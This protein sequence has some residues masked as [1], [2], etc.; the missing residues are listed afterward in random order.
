MLFAKIKEKLLNR[1]NDIEIS[2]VT[3]ESGNSL[4]GEKLFALLSNM[5]VDED[6]FVE[7]P[8]LKVQDKL[9]LLEGLLGIV[10]EEQNPLFPLSVANAGKVLAVGEDG[11]SVDAVEVSG[12]TQLYRHTL[13]VSNNDISTEFDVIST[14]STAYNITDIQNGLF[15]GA[16]G[17]LLIAPDTSSDNWLFSPYQ[18]QI[19][20]SSGSGKYMLVACL[21]SQIVEIVDCG[22]ELPNCVDAITPL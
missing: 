11:E 5:S 22:S 12:G 9:M 6:D 18:L 19:N 8:E 4:D 2:E 17:I 1:R 3:D 15:V 20:Y 14:K 7:I 21:T 16:Y 10:D 13:F